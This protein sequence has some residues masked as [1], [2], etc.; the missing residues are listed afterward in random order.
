MISAATNLVVVLSRGRRM[1]MGP[2][3]SVLA[4]AFHLLLY[5]VGRL[6]LRFVIGAYLDLGKQAHTYELHAEKDEHEW[7]DDPRGALERLDQAG[8][9]VDAEDVVA[10]VSQHNSR[11]HQESGNPE[12]HAD[13]AKE[14]IQKI[15][16]EIQEKLGEKTLKTEQEIK[17]QGS[18]ISCVISI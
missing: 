17:Q 6:A 1:N 18:K 13:L 8:E 7:C 11:K 16:S 3:Y 4:S 12:I 10:D 14:N 2:W 9:G 15:I 5:D